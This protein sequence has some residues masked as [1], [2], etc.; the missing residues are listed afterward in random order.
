M[1]KD[2][3]RPSVINPADY[4]FVCFEYLKV[5]SLGDAEFLTAE[6]ERKARHMQRTG[7]TY[8]RH[9]HGGNCYICG[10]ACIYT[11]LFYHSATNVYLHTGL[12]C[13]EK[14]E[15]QDAEKFRKTV[16]DALSGG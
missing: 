10:A 15:L 11:A 4:E 5:E 2:I 1:R 8:S 14:M 12:E 7:G 13:A 9:E 3:H 6:R 16:Q